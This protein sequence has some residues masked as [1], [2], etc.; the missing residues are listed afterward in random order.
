M[1]QQIPLFPNSFKE[2][3][4]KLLREVDLIEGP[5]QLA[6]WNIQAQTLLTFEAMR[7]LGEQRAASPER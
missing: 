7:Q 2:R 3:A 5:H 6:D 1:S 4:E